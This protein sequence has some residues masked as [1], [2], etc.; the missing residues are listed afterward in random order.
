MER[1]NPTSGLKK[2]GSGAFCQVYRKGKTKVIIQSCCT[3]KRAMSE[4]FFPDS[5]LFPKIKLLD[6]KG[7]W[8]YYEGTYMKVFDEYSTLMSKLNPFDKEFY[9]ELNLAQ[10]LDDHDE[11][12]FDSYAGV[13]KN[14]ETLPNKFHCRKALMIEAVEG[15]SNYGSDMALDVGTKNVALKNG[16]LVLLDCFFF[17]REI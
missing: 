16:K 8:S 7:R 1:N 6:R 15:L 5:P 4:G 9:H 3:V 17:K 12:Y 2:I 10:Y 14:I 11:D 13:I